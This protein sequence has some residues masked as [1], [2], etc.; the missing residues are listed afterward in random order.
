MKKKVCKN[1]KRTKKK[2]EV[3]SRKIGEKLQTKNLLKQIDNNFKHNSTSSL[4]FFF[5]LSPC[6][7]E[8]LRISYRFI[9]TLEDNV[10]VLEIKN[11]KKEDL[12][13]K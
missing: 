6:V 7:Q 12:V 9:V 5:P 11:I 10:I 3:M 13:K 8:K 1:L 2:K 4:E